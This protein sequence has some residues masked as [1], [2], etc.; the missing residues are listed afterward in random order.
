MDVAPDPRGTENNLPEKG[1]KW[2]EILSVAR[3]EFARTGYRAATIR[4]IAEK[5]QVSTRTL[6]DYFTDKL[7]LFN[8]CIN[9]GASRFPQPQLQFGRDPHAALRAYVVAVL[10]H[11]SA[12][13]SLQVSL[14]ISRDTETC[15]EIKEIVKHTHEYYLLRPLAEF[16]QEMRIEADAAVKLSRLFNNMAT[17]EWQRRIMFGEPP[18]DDEAIAAHAALVTSVFLDGEPLRSVLETSRSRR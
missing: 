14:M 4:G 9:A 16:L 13:G 5:A 11:L 6:Y 17:S 15:P 12:E 8:A 1:R 18:M 2:N 7:G 10:Q 3:W